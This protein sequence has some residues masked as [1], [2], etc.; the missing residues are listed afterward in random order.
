MAHYV[1]LATFTDQGLKAA[2][3]SPIGMVPPPPASR[4]DLS[5]IVV[6][7]GAIKPD[8]PRL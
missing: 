6:A 2:K 3:E 1:I 5:A 4:L 7:D 8:R